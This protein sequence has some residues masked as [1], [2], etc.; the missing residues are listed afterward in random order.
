[1]VDRWKTSHPHSRDIKPTSDI[2][3]HDCI[4]TP[5][6][7][8]DIRAKITGIGEWGDDPTYILELF[9]GT[10]VIEYNNLLL[11][12]TYRGG[13][14]HHF[15]IICRN[16]KGGS[17]GYKDDPYYVNVAFCIL[18]I[19][20]NHLSPLLIKHIYSR[21]KP[22]TSVRL[23]ME[24]ISHIQTQLYPGNSLLLQDK[25]KTEC[26]NKK[27]FLLLLR[28]LQG[29]PVDEMSIYNRY[30]FRFVNEGLIEKKRDQ[31]LRYVYDHHQ[32]QFGIISSNNPDCDM[33][34]N[35]L[36]TLQTGLLTLGHPLMD[37][38][39]YENLKTDTITL[40]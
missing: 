36:D 28:L 33:L 9:N 3:Q 26:D 23:A 30:G 22:L 32:E 24:F 12:Y 1:L 34:T 8:K 25:A 19:P 6:E 37:I 40:N 10:D 13:T 38:T 18:K 5:Q 27:V 31:I 16:K 4:L 7:K 11:H 29:A 2:K 39:G 21:R 20:L 15:D 14:T 35:Y 17:G